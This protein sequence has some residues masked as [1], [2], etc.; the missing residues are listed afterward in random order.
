ME[1]S[2]KASCD[3]WQR[4]MALWMRAI[5]R[6]SAHTLRALRADL[7]NPV[8]DKSAPTQKCLPLRGSSIDNLSRTVAS[9]YPCI[10]VPGTAWVYLVD[11]FKRNV[12]NI[13]AERSR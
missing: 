1:S 5:L 12:V 10:Q 8:L 13:E 6:C 11:I 2:V 4:R 3:W 9:G 7:L